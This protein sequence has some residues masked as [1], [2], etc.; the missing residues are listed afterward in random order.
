MEWQLSDV[1]MLCMQHFLPASEMRLSSRTLSIL[2]PRLCGMWIGLIPSLLGDPIYESLLSPATKALAV[3]IIVRSNHQWQLIPE[4]LE[5]NCYA[6]RAFYTTIRRG[7]DTDFTALATSMM[8]LFLS[9]VS[10]WQVVPLVLPLIR[11]GSQLLL[12]TST[13][14]FAIHAEGIATVLQRF[15]PASYATGLPHRLFTSFQLVIVRNRSFVTYSY[16]NSL[17]RYF[18]VS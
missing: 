10:V 12:P 14:S 5:L 17:S 1:V 16:P 18:T 6:C 15:S 2:Q 11:I 3:S 9:E 4:A 7:I 8:C 13:V